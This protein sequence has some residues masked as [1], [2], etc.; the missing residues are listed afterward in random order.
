MDEFC[1]VVVGF[2]VMV[3]EVKAGYFG[4]IRLF[5]E[6]K[7]SNMAPKRNQII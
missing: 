7:I 1:I 4:E 3:K 6:Y 5:E 2:A